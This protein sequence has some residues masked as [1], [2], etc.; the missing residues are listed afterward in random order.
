AWGASRVLAIVCASYRMRCNAKMRGRTA[1]RPVMQVRRQPFIKS[2]LLQTASCSHC[3]LNK[4]FCAALK[5]S[6]YLTRNRHRRA[7]GL[8]RESALTRVHDDVEEPA[9]GA[10]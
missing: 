6:Q 10:T 7:Q 2:I 1:C 3:F 4:T 8:S 9:I 5:P